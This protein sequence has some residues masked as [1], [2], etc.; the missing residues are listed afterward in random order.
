VLGHPH[1]AQQRLTVPAYVGRA[2]RGDQRLEGWPGRRGR[3]GARVE[4]PLT[5]AGEISELRLRFAVRRAIGLYTPKLDG[6]SPGQVTSV[7]DTTE[8]YAALA[9]VF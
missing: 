9:V 5:R 8:I 1:R 6:A 4:L 3:P 7:G 2:P